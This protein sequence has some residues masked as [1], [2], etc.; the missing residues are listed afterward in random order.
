MKRIKNKLL[1]IAV[2]ISILGAFISLFFMDG[3]EV[4]LASLITIFVTG[5]AGGASLTA[6][7]TEIKKENKKNT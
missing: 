1:L 5:F 2:I 7:I 4:G 6:Y 3:Q